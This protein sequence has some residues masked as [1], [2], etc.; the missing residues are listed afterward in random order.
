MEIINRMTGG[1]FE[2]LVFCQDRETG[3]KAIVA[4]HDTTLGP[5]LGGTRMWPYGSEEE[6]IVD[7][8]RLARGMTYKAAVA[9]LSL[10]GG[11]AVIIGSPADK[12]ETLLRAY[13]RFV[14]TLKGRYITAEDVG[15]CQ[16]DM[17]VI[18]RETQHV[19]GCDPA[20]GGGGDPSPF[21]A[22]GVYNGIKAAVKKRYGTDSLNGLTVAVQGPGN[23]GYHLC[24]LLAGEC[25]RLVVTDIN[26]KVLQKAA[27]EFGAEAVATDGIYDSHCHVF[28]PCA[29][30]A[31]VNDETIEK[32]RC[33]II[34][35]AA[36][37]VLAEERHG[38][39]L[40]KRG[41]LY[42]PDYVINAGGLINVADELYGY[43]RQR[44]DQRVAQIYNTVLDVLTVSEK[45]G[46]PTHRAA[47]R[48]AEQRIKQAKMYKNSGQ[49]EVP[50]VG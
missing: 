36:N 49:R 27:G 50:M 47:D 30:G 23:V 46:I 22:R 26:P 10:G 41:I 2:Q 34:A 1:G 44:V 35:G 45:D 18:H 16:W 11:K 20:R 25:A 13:G 37:N 40:R 12:T 32:F 8:M 5:A 28:A 42:V 21:T 39:A 17:D 3:L 7:V 15:T 4:I 24:R 19:T 9:G 38:D 43:Q 29:L 14:D 6:A 48:L 33:A 31:V